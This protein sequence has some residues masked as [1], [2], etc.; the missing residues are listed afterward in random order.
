VFTYRH[1]LKIYCSAN[2]RIP[3]PNFLKNDFKI[4]VNGKESVFFRFGPGDG[5]TKIL[6]EKG[7]KNPHAFD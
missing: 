1:D 5:R 6:G 7:K 3:D 2:P 4:S